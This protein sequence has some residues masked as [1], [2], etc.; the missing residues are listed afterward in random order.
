MLKPTLF[1]IA[2][3]N[4][5]GKSSY[6]NAVT[7]DNI[8]PFDYD[9]HFLEFYNSIIVFELRPKM[10]HN[11]ARNL[12][13]KSV[14]KA[15]SEEI[16]FCYETNFNATPMYWPDHFKKHGYQRTV[17]FFCLNSIEEAK[18][19]VRIRVENGGHFVPDFEIENRYYAGYENFDKYFKSFDQVH[20]LNSSFYKK[21]PQHIL[22]IINGK[23]GTVTH[24][25][26]FIRKALPKLSRL[27]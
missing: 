21:Q 10:A 19:R 5:S 25:P 7:P 14:K 17:F 16:D 12:L 8:T 26:D 4:G 23:V 18:R 1:I 22:S 15:I 2:G 20:L 11:K 27:I 6:S 3:C 13:E 24:M 9:K